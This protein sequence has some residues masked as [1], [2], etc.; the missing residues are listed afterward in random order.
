[1]S[2]GKGHKSFPITD[3][4]DD[5]SAKKQFVEKRVIDE[6]MIQ[7]Y[8]SL[9]TGECWLIPLVEREKPKDSPI[10]GR[11]KIRTCLIFAQL[12]INAGMYRA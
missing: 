11:T 5:G 2:V 1:M 12:V 9:T 10:L 7:H 4:C 3:S 6:K 8:W